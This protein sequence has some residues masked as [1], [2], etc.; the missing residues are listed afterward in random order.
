MDTAAHDGFLTPVP[1]QYLWN[2]N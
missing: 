2:I 1:V